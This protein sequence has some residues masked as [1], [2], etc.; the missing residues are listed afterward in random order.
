M[1]SHIIF[2]TDNRIAV[3]NL[4]AY[5]VTSYT[6]T[7]KWQSTLSD[8]TFKISCPIKRGYPAIKPKFTKETTYLGMLCSC[9]E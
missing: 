1:P 4:T 8:T 7:L 3:A 9:I 6:V 5:D 2:K